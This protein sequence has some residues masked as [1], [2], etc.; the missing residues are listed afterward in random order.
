MIALRGG[1]WPVGE[2]RAPAEQ[3]YANETRQAR[4]TQQTRAHTV[5][6]HA[7]KCHRS[8]LCWVRSRQTNFTECLHRA[9]HVPIKGRRVKSL[10]ANI[11]W[12]QI[13]SGADAR[14]KQN[15][16]WW[17]DIFR[18][19]R[20]SRVVLNSASVFVKLQGRMVAGAYLNARAIIWLGH[21]AALC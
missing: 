10:N 19:I 1:S 7:L 4:A 21:T 20:D 16:R 3:L 9:K 14:F 18:N 15:F 13:H 2:G 6:A 8:A 5:G 11:R 12:A 17:W